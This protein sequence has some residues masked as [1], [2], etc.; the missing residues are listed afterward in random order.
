MSLIKNILK[1]RSIESKGLPYLLTVVFGLFFLM[2]LAGFFYFALKYGILEDEQ[3]PWY[4]IALLLCSYFG[5]IL[6]RRI[7]DR[8]RQTAADLSHVV[9]EGRIGLPLPATD[10]LSDIARSFRRLEGEWRSGILALD[11]RVNQISTLKELS[12]LCYATFDGEDLFH[13]TLERALK[14]T[15]ADVG[16]ALL[17]EK[18]DRTTF[19][20]QAAIG[21]GDVLQVGDRI[22]YASSIAKYAIINKSPLL[23]DDI[24]SDSRFGRDNRT[25]YGT[26]SF[27]CM[28]LKG[29]HEVMG[30]LNLSRRHDDTP[31]TEDDVNVLTPLLSTAAFTF[32][33][34]NLLRRESETTRHLQVLD[35]AL[36]STVSSLKNHELRHVLLQ[37]LNDDIPCDMVALLL[38]DGQMQDRLVVLDRTTGSPSSLSAGVSFPYE[39]SLFDV[40]MRSGTGLHHSELSASLNGAEQTVFG[41]SHCRSAYIMP[42]KTRGRSLGVLVVGSVKRDAFRD[43]GVRLDRFACVLSLVVGRDLLEASVLKRDRDLESIKRIGDVLA[44]S[45]FD[46]DEVLNHTLEMIRTLMEVDAGRLLLIRGEMLEVRASFHEN[47]AALPDKKSTKI[48]QGIVGHCAARGEP[49]LIRDGPSFP[50]LDHACDGHPAVEIHGVLCVPVIAQGRVLGVIEVLNKKTGEFD[51]GDMQLLQS[52]AA[53]LSVALENARLYRET[54]ARAERELEIRRMFQQ[55]VP[56]EVVEKMT[57]TATDRA[58]IEELRILTFLNIDLRSFSKLA[59]RLGPQKTVSILNRFFAVMG[60]VVFSHHGIVDKYLGDGFLALF[61]AP[62]S[63]GVDADN[64]IAAA[65]DM[66][67]AMA[68]LNR[69]LTDE[70]DN[71]LIIGISIH[72]GEAVVGNIGFE[73]KMDYTVIGDAVNVVFRLQDLARAVPDG[74]LISDR[75]RLALMKSG[76]NLIKMAPQPSNDLPEDMAVYEVL[77]QRWRNP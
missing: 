4:F 50:G 72:T 40:S 11:R 70:L 12:D 27:L 48:G 56:Q 62:V 67:R 52:V 30:V 2:P 68:D 39:G 25:R 22:D 15:G 64:A 29:I 42:L 28:P 38:V 41:D 63:T 34:I 1:Q 58:V 60:E 32:D 16:S 45:T 57:G 44:A 31:F 10:E 20:V 43:M 26:K 18:P 33:N 9:D 59:L 3:L 7:F 17:L 23:V 54:V 13:I 74:I 6:I 77:D 19:V 24:E 69:D 21:L 14:L 76:V 55:Y 46:L 71:P 36:Q 37:H 35:A 66:K 49:L 8:I 5:Y 73:K 47:A 53:S 61:G 65:L 75:T 51:A